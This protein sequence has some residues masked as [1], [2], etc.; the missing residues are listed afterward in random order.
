MSSE[1]KKVKPDV[2]LGSTNS[3]LSQE[4][5]TEHLQQAGCPLAPNAASISE[6]TPCA[7]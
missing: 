1:T 4:R 3:R 5:H 6:Q 7:V 2:S